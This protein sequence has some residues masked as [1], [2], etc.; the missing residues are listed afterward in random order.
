MQK[1]K[2]AMQEG[3]SSDIN[4]IEFSAK[5]KWIW[6]YNDAILHQDKKSVVILVLQIFWD[7]KHMFLLEQ[8]GKGGIHNIPLDLWN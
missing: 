5:Y 8:K 4:I 1:A 7:G 6:S 2:E 3:G